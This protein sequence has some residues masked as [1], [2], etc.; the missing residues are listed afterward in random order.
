MVAEGFR[1]QMG[2]H[3]SVRT[4]PMTFTSRESSF[5]FLKPNEVFDRKENFRLK[6]D[7]DSDFPIKP[8][9]LDGSLGSFSMPASFNVPAACV[10]AS[11]ELS[12]DL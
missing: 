12:E 8:P 10:S 7:P 4:F 2:A 3:T 1:S 5:K 9:H 11:E 6:V